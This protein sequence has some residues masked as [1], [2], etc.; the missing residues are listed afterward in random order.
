M[1][2]AIVRKIASLHSGRAWVEGDVE[3]GARFYVSLSRR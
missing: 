3:N 1:G 2:L